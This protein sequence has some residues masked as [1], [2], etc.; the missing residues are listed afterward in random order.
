MYTYSTLR[1]IGPNPLR[2][3]LVRRELA[4]TVGICTYLWLSLVVIFPLAHGPGYK[5]D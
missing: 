1:P 3:V 4:F 5:F 2:M